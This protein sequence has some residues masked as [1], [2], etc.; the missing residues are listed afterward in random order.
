MLIKR[1]IPDKIDFSAGE[2][3]LFDKEKGISSFDIIRRLKRIVKI[4]KIGHAGTLDPMATGLVILCTGKLTKQIDNYQGM[5]KEYE[6]VITLGGN[7]PSYDAETEVEQTFDYTSISEDQI[8]KVIN[9]FLG[10]IEQIP[11]M[12]SALKFQ[13]ERLYKKARKGEWV[14]RK[15]RKVHIFEFDIQKIALPDIHFRVK[16]SKGTYIRTLAHDIGKSLN[17]G[18][19]L[20]ALRRTAIGNFSVNDAFSLEE[21]A[22]AINKT[23]VVEL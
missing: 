14:E 22:D 10:E 23:E 12:Y 4:K 2:V 8:H 20:T 7:T 15:A 19:Y 13:G 9:Q 18:G 11:P 21:F 3:I 17:N 6:G 16:C 1:N 5:V